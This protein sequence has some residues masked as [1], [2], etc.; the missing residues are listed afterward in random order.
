[1]GLETGGPPSINEDATP[2]AQC[3]DGVPTK[4]AS[5][6][7]SEVS[8]SASMTSPAKRMRVKPANMSPPLWRPPGDGVPSQAASI[9]GQGEHRLAAAWATPGSPTSKTTQPRTSESP[10]A[11]KMR[12]RLGYEDLD[13]SLRKIRSKDESLQMQMQMR[14]NNTRR[15]DLNLL[16]AVNTCSLT[17]FVSGAAF[18]N[19]SGTVVLSNAVLIGVQANYMALNVDKACDPDKVWEFVGLAFTTYFLIEL[20]LR[21][22][23]H[24]ME[25][26][27]GGDKNWNLFDMTIV[28]FGVLEEVVRLTM[29]A[30]PC[31]GEV[32]VTKGITAIRVFRVMRL[33]R[34]VRA[35]RTMHMFRELRVMV[36]SIIRCLIPL[37][38]ACVLLLVVEWCFGVYFLQIATDYRAVQAH[39]QGVDIL[40][41]DAV[42]VVLE[43]FY[44]SLWKTLFTLFQ[45][46]TGGIDWKEPAMALADS[47]TTNAL[48]MFICYIA[49]T[50]FAVLNVV[51]GVFVEYATKM[52]VNDGDIAIQDRKAETEKLLQDALRVFEEVDVNKDGILSLDEFEERISDPRV[53]LFFSH[54][55]LDASEARRLFRLID[56]DNNNSVEADEFISG[57]LCL[58]GQATTLDVA[59][60]MREQRKIVEKIEN[61][62][63]VMSDR[64]NA[65]FQGALN[66]G[67]HMCATAAAQMIVDFNAPAKGVEVVNI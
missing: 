19:F 45:S 12:E 21:L 46:I 26:F 50:V 13:V 31:A 38:W 44:S 15:S 23:A 16:K 61:C 3:F 20:V 43:E 37:G 34:I 58:R 54:M 66:G 47:G 24:R 51:T 32:N 35:I 53:Q 60:L 41:T 56:V 29:F 9:G 40:T 62:L 49:L 2:G 67:G 14:L 22:L 28:V 52:A 36:H 65:G 11:R 64:D 33:V 17:K 10:S 4:L 42:A 48:F 8:E 25:F 7:D 63:A 59:A 5:S 57:C 6:R 39:Q 18:E 1:M 27:T 55:E 30:D